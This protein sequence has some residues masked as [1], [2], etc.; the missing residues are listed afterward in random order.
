MGFRFQRRLKLF[1][2]VRLNF[3]RGGIST[4]IGARGAS[5]T[6][7]GRGTYLNL[8]IPGTGL[9]FRQR[10]TPSVD[11]TQKVAVPSPDR[12]PDGQRPPSPI[13][14]PTP[15]PKTYPD[16]SPVGAIRSAPVSTLTSVGLDELKKLINEAA[17]R[18]V[19]LTTAA[20]A[21]ALAL[22]KAERRLRHA[23]WFIIRL[24]T[25]RSL[26]KLADSVAAAEATL[27]ETRRNLA[28]CSIEIEFAFDEPTLSA[29]AAV[30][31]EFESI[32]GCQ[33]IWDITAA[34]STNRL[35]ERTTA[36]QRISRK[37]VKLNFSSSKIIDTNYKAL[38]FTN[39]N[40]ND[41]YIYPGFVMMRNLGGDF[42]LIDVRELEVRRS[43]S[44]F[45]EEESVPTDSEII[46]QTWYK[47]NKDGS[48][49]RRFAG[50]YQIPIARYAEIEFHSS[51]GLYEVYQ[52]SNYSRAVNFFK[53]LTDYQKAVAAMAER[54]KDHSLMPLMASSDDEPDDTDAEPAFAPAHSMAA[55][56]SAPRFLIF[57]FVSLIIVVA[58]L[59]WGV[60]QVTRYPID[61]QRA[62]RSLMQ[63]QTPVPSIPA[64]AAPPQIE[65]AH[66]T[67]TAM[68]VV[69]I[70]RTDANV[71]VEPSVASQVIAHEH[72]GKRLNVFQRQGGWVRIGEQAPVGWV[73]KG[74]V[75]SAPP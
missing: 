47:A 19:E 3:S 59:G 45:I 65:R 48:R 34:I 4:T 37:P 71:R 63:P 24:F 51:T 26:P 73:Y 36:T 55:L 54:S 28:G 61:L 39:A 27:D 75:G 10:I 23:R 68:E 53:A 52:F 14:E 40:G 50:N 70:Q 42:A 46:G 38:H 13:P 16:T 11:G 25:S 15:T 69:Y 57:D 33:K 49:D 22:K 43:Q 56:P 67:S 66:E 58:A 6:L 21:D 12:S 1:P 32:S 74:L 5:V 9:S 30:V 18:S 60:V 35:I 17:V 8:G 62:L 7:S 29:F 41:I 44:S 64:V 2:G 31:R 20:S 72:A